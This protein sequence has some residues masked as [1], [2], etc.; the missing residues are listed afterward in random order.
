MLSC[1]QWVDPDDVS[2]LT[3][4]VAYV[5][6][7]IHIPLAISAQSPTLLTYLPLAGKHSSFLK[8]HFAVHCSPLFKFHSSIL[9]V[10]TVHCSISLPTGTHA[11]LTGESVGPNPKLRFSIADKM[12]AKSITERRFTPAASQATLDSIFEHLASAAASRNVGD[13]IGT[14]NGTK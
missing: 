10:H 11:P 6:D 3:Y 4:T 1:W 14:H 8:I 5:K 2:I 7:Y 12:G 13:I 9:P